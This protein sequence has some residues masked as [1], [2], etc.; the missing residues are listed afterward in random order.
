MQRIS[1]SRGRRTP[2]VSGRDEAGEGKGA[3]RNGRRWATRAL[4]VSKECFRRIVETTHEGIWMADLQGVTIFANPQMARLLGCTAEE[5]I[6]HPVFDFVFAEDHASVR[7][8][9]AQFLRAPAGQRIEER[10]RRKDG[11]ELW[12]LVAAS[13]FRNQKDQP[14]GFLG[15]FADV[16]ERRRM[17][18][19]LRLSMGTLET[20]VQ[21]RTAEL[22]RSHQALAESEEKYRRLFE[23]ISDAAL[24]FD[25]ET[26]RFL[27][28]NAAALRLY[29]Y[30]R[31]EFLQL[32]HAATTVQPED[33]EASIQLVL[34]GAAPHIPVRYHRRKD[35]T[36]FPVEIAGS[37]F[38]LNGRPMVCGIIRDI[39]E[40]KRAE[41]AIAR[42]RELER[43]ILAI[44]EREQ[45]RLGQ[46]LHDDLCQQLAG[47]SFLSERLAGRLTA[48][49][50]ATAAQAREITRM[51]EHAMTR[52]RDLARGL[53]PVGLQAN[54]LAD[55]LRALAAHTKKVFQRDCR[56]RGGEPVLVPD[57]TSSFHLY[58][59]AQEAV[60]NAVKHGRARLIEIELTTGPAPGC[61]LTLAVRDNGIGF[62]PKSRPAK[63]MGLRIM[64]YRA[65]VLGGSLSISRQP[66]GGTAVVVCNVPGGPP[67]PGARGLK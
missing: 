57:P 2:R 18:A 46:D 58:R 56:F 55:A 38:T 13:V 20:R 35:G 66:G 31:E 47:I 39:T 5:M 44:S 17:E 63:G 36:V 27:E 61:A 42:A 62:R 54:G 23:S 43:E 50:A 37:T 25:A 29:G 10:L 28:A 19:G 12:A 26:R 33:S 22:Q 45:Q 4:R 34:S 14:V 64:Q 30:T 11:T 53:S 7:Q 48:Q 49:G 15:M 32:T 9:F 67:L 1:K 3:A 16:T 8:H 60:S 51:L 41:E 24:V 65:E 21:E 59:I 52:T 40:R 6:G